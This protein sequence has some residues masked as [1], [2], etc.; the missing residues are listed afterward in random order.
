MDVQFRLPPYLAGAWREHPAV[1]TRSVMA[2]TT[3]FFY[4]TGGSSI[5]IGTLLMGSEVR[6]PGWVL[7]I[8]L[9]SVL[10]GVTVLATQG[11]MP[12]SMVHALTLSGT[13]LIAAQVVLGGGGVASIVLSTAYLY[14]MVVAAFLPIRT[15]LVHVLT[16]QVA[17]AWAMIA[18]GISPGAVVVLGACA[19]SVTVVLGWLGRLSDIAEQ[20]PLTQLTNRR[21]FDRRLESA[22]REAGTARGGLALILL[23]VDLFRSLNDRRGHRY[24]DQ[25]LIGC[26]E[27]WRSLVPESSC[28]S[29]YGGDEF[30]ILLPGCRLGHAADLA[31][32]LRAA[33]PPHLTVSVGVA[34]WEPGDSGS[35]LMSRADVALYQAKSAGRDRTVAHGDPGRSASE[36][37]SAVA[38]RELFAAFQPIVKLSTRE[39]IGFESLVRW[40]SPRRGLVMPDA[41]IPEAE[42]TGAIHSLGAWLVDEVCREAVAGPGPRCSI[43]INVS[44]AELASSE[45]APMVLDRMAA[46]STPGNLLV[47]EVTEGAFDEE[48]AQVVKTLCTLREHGILVAID[49]FGAG[50]SSLRRLDTLPIDILKVDGALVQAIGERDDAP[51]LAAIAAMAR[52]LNLRLVAERVETEHQAAVL[53]SLGYDLAQGFLFGRPEPR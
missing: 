21:G 25:L 14:V 38:A 34:A 20:D 2:R 6:H 5:T 45:Y 7:A 32:R 8:A 41:F 47:L 29:R 43:G 28:L 19:L 52:A 22:V 26:A 50:Y 39:T 27:A 37:E 23:D 17:A 42:R 49:D 16:A 53:A 12:R 15:A 24:G 48:D 13:G 46:H 3:G 4:L 10:T 33:T 18:S 9:V 40:Q 36:L 44:P 1:A 30:A 11:R 51:I 35:I 31:D